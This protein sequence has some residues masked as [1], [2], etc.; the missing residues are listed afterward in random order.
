MML[1]TGEKIKPP[2]AADKKLARDLLITLLIA[3]AAIS[4][5]IRFL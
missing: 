4:F 2:S 5:E 1:W 3:I